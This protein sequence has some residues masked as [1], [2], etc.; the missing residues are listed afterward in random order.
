MRARTATTG[1]A[2]GPKEA[3]ATTKR[4]YTFA[5]DSPTAGA[6]CRLIQTAAPIPAG[7]SLR[8][9]PGDD[10]FAYSV[11]TC[12][13]PEL[14]AMAYFRA[15]ISIDDTALQIVKWRCGNLDRVGTF[16]DFAAG[17]GRSTHFLAK[18]LSTERVCIPEIQPDALEF[19]SREFGVCTLLSEA[20]P[21]NVDVDATHDVV[22]VCSLIHLPE[23]TFAPWLR[24]LW[25]SV[26]PGGMVSFSVHDQATVRVATDLPDDGFA[27]M[28][29]YVR[30]Q[31]EGAIGLDEALETIRLPRALRFL[32]DVWIVCN[33]QWPAG[34]L[35]YECAPR[36]ALDELLVAGRTMRLR[37]WVADLGVAS[38]KRASHLI[39]DVAVYLNDAESTRVPT[40]LVR[41]RR[42]RA[43]RVSGRQDP[44]A[45]RLGCNARR[46]RCR[47]VGCIRL[48][49]KASSMAGSTRWV[50]MR[51]PLR[52]EQCPSRLSGISGSAIFTGFPRQF[53]T[54]DHWAVPR[55]WSTERCTAQ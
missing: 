45:V 35:C 11:N 16:L 18:H 31:I 34:K 25:S 55:R 24:L 7:V 32:R 27:F 2:V 12:A 47:P 22:F 14:A 36:G 8:V 17:Y 54:Q 39:R 9:D 3:D 23:R 29:P 4:S 30:R 26:G 52:W 44:H 43:S 49:R 21:D 10:M 5:E 19:Q 42:N 38:D 33:G 41:P 50:S 40:A 1:N 46:S 15:G 37:G 6:V 51:A 13:T 53:T 48:V 20:D 28:E